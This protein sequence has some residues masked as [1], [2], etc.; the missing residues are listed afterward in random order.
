MK[1]KKLVSIIL[2]VIILAMM[3]PLTGCFQTVTVPSGYIGRILNPSGW[4]SA[5]LPPGQVNI[6][7]GSITG[8]QSKLVLI[9]ATTI[10]YLETFRD[11]AASDDKHDHRIIT[12]D[13]VPVAVDMYVRLTLPN[14][15]SMRDRIFMEVTP[16]PWPE[17]KN[18]S[19]IT[20]YNV[21]KRFVEMDVR[22]RVRDIVSSYDKFQDLLGA[23]YG[24]ANRKI[25]AAAIAAFKTA[26]I[27][28]N[29]EDAQLSQILP[30][31][32]VWDS[33]VKKKAAEAFQD[34]IGII[35]RSIKDNPDYLEYLKWQALQ[36]IAATGAAKGN[37]LIIVTDSKTT[38]GLV[39]N[40][41]GPPATT[42][43][44]PPAPNPAQ[45]PTPTPTKK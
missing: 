12:R 29:L 28:L 42:V 7:A 5:I 24:E 26:N 33:E 18:I 3:L 32:Q 11:A 10:T 4:E 44:P 13:G 6:G 41:Y 1:N 27:P 20:L 25:T 22:N 43:A 31:P 17:N 45:T 36:A 19:V 15:K 39:I 2:V 8:Q 38:P 30:D 21:Y 16:E 14:D 35:G 40:P 9:E 34:Q 37:N 23:G